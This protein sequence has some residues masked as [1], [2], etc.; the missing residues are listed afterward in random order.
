MNEIIIATSAPVIFF[1]LA[2]LC[3]R[4]R[5]QYSTY[6][7]MAI[8]YAHAAHK[9][10]D[11]VTHAIKNMEILAECGASDEALA[12]ALLHDAPV[13]LSD[14]Q[15]LFGKTTAELVREGK[16]CGA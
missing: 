3:L 7:T 10:Q 9:T 14:I 16:C 11:A 8:G 15:E 6:V 12:A 5:A 4:P 13:P 2:W 1:A